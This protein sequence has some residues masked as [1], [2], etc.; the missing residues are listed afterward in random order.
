MLVSL[1][2]WLAKAKLEPAPERSKL[3]LISSRALEAREQQ[4]KREWF[5]ELDDECPY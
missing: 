1:S 3:G 4:R 2:E 5:Q